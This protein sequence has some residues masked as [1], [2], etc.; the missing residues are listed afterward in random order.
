[1]NLTELAKRKGYSEEI[2]KFLQEYSILNPSG[3]AKKIEQQV[4]ERELI[5]Y[6]FSQTLDGPVIT[7]NNPENE[8]KEYYDSLR[9]EAEKRFESMS[10][11][12]RFVFSPLQS[13]V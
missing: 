2:Q 13:S 7:T 12:G 1:M 4:S 6:I 9:R 10:V 8:M 11:N 3:V 5:I